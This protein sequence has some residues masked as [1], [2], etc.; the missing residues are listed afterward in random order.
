MVKAPKNKDKKVDAPSTNV[1][2]TLDY[3]ERAGLAQIMALDIFRCSLNDA[4]EAVRL[5]DTVAI[6]AEV[7]KSIGGTIDEA[8]GN[9]SMP[10]SRLKELS[11][12]IEIPVTLNDYIREVCKRIDEAKAVQPSDTNLIAIMKKYLIK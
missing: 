5:R 12:D 1:K 7:V 8:T 10:I 11:L 6:T 2:H 3:T 9:I 4:L